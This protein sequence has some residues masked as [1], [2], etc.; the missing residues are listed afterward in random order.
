MQNTS[1]EWYYANALHQFLLIIALHIMCNQYG[2]DNTTSNLEE[3]GKKRASS[4]KQAAGLLLRRFKFSQ[5]IGLAQVKA[6]K[7]QAHCDS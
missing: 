3:N 7:L 6:Q 4:H 1:S 2:S 5:L